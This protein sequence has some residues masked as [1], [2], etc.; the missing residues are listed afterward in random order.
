M[1]RSMLFFCVV[2]VWAVL[3]LA[4]SQGNTVGARLSEPALHASNRAAFFDTSLSQEAGPRKPARKA[5]RVY[6]FKRDAHGR[7]L[8]GVQLNDLD[9]IPFLFDTAATDTL[10]YKAAARRLYLLPVSGLGKPVWTATGTVRS[11]TYDLAHLSVLANSRTPARLGSIPGPEDSQAAG[12][13]GVDMMRGWVIEI[14]PQASLLRYDSNTNRYDQQAWPAVQGRPVG[15]GSLALDVR[16][17]GETLAFIVDTGASHTVVNSHAA[18]LLVAA[19]Y[20]DG[21]SS[22]K[23]TDSGTNVRDTHESEAAGAGALQ[24]PKGAAEQAKP[25]LAS[26]SEAV[27]ASVPNPTSVP[28]PSSDQQPAQVLAGAGGAGAYIRDMRRPLHI[29]PAPDRMRGQAAPAKESA[30]PQAFLSLSSVTVADLPIFRSIGADH[31][32]AGILG[33]DV[34]AGKHLAFDLRGWRLLIAPNE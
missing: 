9:E 11:D 12:I 10:I 3:G 32:P 21:D 17:G 33:M 14:D 1:V 6:A 34:L 28:G 2:V 23:P 22:A 4:P 29:G 20:L 5:E 7:M 24:N 26:E 13:V 27:P 30:A 19:G 8:V 25:K 16:V 18:R 31:A 15:R